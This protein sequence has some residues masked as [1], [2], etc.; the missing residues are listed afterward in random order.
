ML[1]VTVGIF[2]WS[3]FGEQVIAANSV[4]KMDDGL[5]SMEYKCDYGVSGLMERGGA[6]N[7]DELAECRTEQR[8]IAP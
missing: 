3:M 7:S 4:T 2:A 1:L 5:Y 8:L 6:V